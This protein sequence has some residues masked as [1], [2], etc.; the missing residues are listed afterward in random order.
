MW[1]SR[2]LLAGLAL[3][4]V[5]NFLADGKLVLPSTPPRGFNSFDLQWNGGG[6]YIAWNESTF[7]RVATAM[8]KQLLPYGYDTLVVDGGWHGGSVDGNGRPV[9]NPANWPS[10]T[11]GAG[12]KPLATWAHGLGLKVGV[13]RMRG[14]PSAAVGKQ[15][16]VLNSIPPATIDEI[17]Y[18]RSCPQ[19]NATERWCTCT[20]DKDGIGVDP[21]HPAAQ[22]YYNSVVS[23][24]ADWGIDLIKWDCMY[25]DVA[26]SFNQEETMAV[27]AIEAVE[28]PM[29]LSLSPGGGFTKEIASWVSGS[30]PSSKVLGTMYRVTGDFHAKPGIPYV[31]GLPAHVFVVG[32]LTRSAGEQF[33]LIGANNTWPGKCEVSVKVTRI[34]CDFC[35][36]T[37]LNVILQLSTILH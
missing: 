8:S 24:Y 22:A 17:V 9:P 31:D 15:L 35:S 11:D 16:P 18:G 26:G 19:S 5:H 36:V 6:S 4:H 23:L 27:N 30:N 20:W 37:F 25:D 21:T 2:T 12:F 13:W 7:R 3:L 10:A 32:N 34:R 29:T 1:S 33:A 14:V 28:H